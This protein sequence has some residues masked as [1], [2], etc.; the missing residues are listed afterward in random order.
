MIVPRMT[1]LSKPGFASAQDA[2]VPSLTTLN[3]TFLDRVKR[4][5]AKG[6]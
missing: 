4:A 2:F 3:D 5:F 1:K 6:A